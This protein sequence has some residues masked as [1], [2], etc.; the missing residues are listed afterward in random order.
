MIRINIYNTPDAPSEK[1]SATASSP[2]KLNFYYCEGEAIEPLEVKSYDEGAFL[3]GGS[4]NVFYWYRSE[5]DALEQDSTKRL[6]T[7]DPRGLIIQPSEM[8]NDNVSFADGN[9]VIT[10]PTDMSGTPVPGTYTFY[11]TQASNKKI[12]PSNDVNGNPYVGD[13]YYGEESEPLELTIYVRNVPIAPAV[14]DQTLFICETDVTPTFR[15]SGFDPKITYVWYDSLAVS[16]ASEQARGQ[17]FTPANYQNS[18]AQ[19]PG[20]YGYDVTQITDINLNNEGF[21]GCESPV[22]ELML[23]VRSIPDAPITTGTNDIY[24]IC[25]RQDVLTLVID[26]PDLRNTARYTWYDQDNAELGRGLTFDPS[27]Y[28]PTTNL[29][30]EVANDELFRVKY[31]HHI[32]TAENFAG[33]TSDFTDVIHRTNGLAELSFVDIESDNEYCLELT[34]IDFG[35]ETLGIGGSGRFSLFADFNTTGS[36]LTD[37]GDGTAV[38]NLETLHLQDVDLLDPQASADRLVV[39]GNATYRNIYYEFTDVN[40]C[41]NTDS[42]LN[43]V[44]NPYPAIDFRIDDEVTENYVTCLNDE[45]NI[46]GERTFFLE[47]F[48]TETGASIAKQ[49]QLSDFRIY[50]ELNNE[51]EVGIL[52]DLS[53]RAEFSPQDARKSLSTTDKDIQDYSAQNYY[54]LTLTHRDANGCTNTV[55]NRI[56]INP[57]P[58]FKTQTIGANEYIINNKACATETV[59]FDVD[60]ENI[61]DDQTTFTWFVENDQITDSQDLYFPADDDAVSVFANDY[62]IGGGETTIVLIAK[63]DNTGCLNR[64]SETKQIGVVPDVRFNFKNLTI[65]KETAF[66]FEERELDIRYSQVATAEMTVWDESDN[67]VFQR[68]IFMEDDQDLVVNTANKIDPG[69]DTLTFSN[70]GIYK[71]K[72]YFNSSA[73]CNSSDSV[74]FNILDKIV[75]GPEGILHTFNDGPEGWHTD[76]TSVDGFYQGLND[77]ILGR[78]LSTDQ[79]AASIPRYSTWEWATPDGRTLNNNNVGE[80]NVSGGAWITN[81]D[82]AYA[83]RKRNEN[84]VAENSWVYSPTY[85]LSQ[86]EKPAISFNY[87]SDMVNRDGVVLQ[88]SI[89]EGYTWTPIGEYD[90]EDGNSGINWYNASALP[91]NPG[92]IDESSFSLYNIE[93]FGW[94]RATNVPPGSPLGTASLS[95]DYNWYYAANKI[96][97]KDENGVYLIPNE[98]WSDIRFRFALG[99]NPGEKL[100]ENNNPIEGFAFDNFRIYD[101]QKVI[102]FE[103]FSSAL[104]EDSKTAE[105]IINDRVQKAGAGVVWVNYF[106]DLDGQNN[107]PTD[108]LFIRNEIDPGARGGYYGISESPTSVLDGEVIER[109]PIADNQSGR[110]LGWNQFALNKKELVDPQFDIA[111][112]ELAS[113]TTDELKIRGTFTSLINIP[114]N[115][116]LSF[117]FIVFENYVTGKD[118]GN[119]VFSDT[120]RNVMRAILPDAGGFVEKGSASIGDTY[121]FDIDW[122]IDA[123][124]NLDEL[125]VVAF[126]QNEVTREI[127]QVASINIDN[128]T[129]TLTGLENQIVR[130]V[131]FTIYPNP[132]NQSFKV[133]FDDAIPMDTKWTL[134]DQMGRIM[135]EGI[136]DKNRYELIIET[137]EISS[138]LYFLQLY[139]EMY[140]WEPK[141]VMIIH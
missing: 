121:E 77:S 30:P 54:T 10:T 100:D 63:D 8:K 97:A 21:E 29:N 49:G 110:L 32:N 107:R 70:P 86:L 4:E 84:P 85:D 42:V 115:S 135:K 1:S 88:Y 99:S 108:S 93:Q 136:M 91:G 24:T 73:N 9:G 6:A 58:Q 96:D 123:I 55:D 106:T 125:R 22:T 101:R 68:D 113:N 18:G 43:I 11:V 94:T 60:M 67:V 25:E 62:N 79:I 122:T 26:N 65:G 98:R 71:A 92:N 138:G 128:K 114:P 7:A 23:T 13:P 41:V 19:V 31:T 134:F 129:N 40:G 34:D 5:A 118:F 39:G 119:Y 109:N 111:L 2:G 75:V 140:R 61:Q 38:L 15:I 81:A 36:G 69:F 141:R 56:T 3:S 33:C 83:N 44:V 104:L 80:T 126:V 16:S 105:D 64:A 82:G 90:F 28:V 59:E 130:G 127:Y 35:A 76:S 48:Y 117:R 53:A 87:A 102:L 133:S 45:S 132:A 47:G 52:S 12:S 116:E 50:D 78:P 139:D 17:T 20:F 27:F 37:N 112:V 51:L 72:F 46:L 89:D 120:I 66:R 137:G 124:F 103:S 14:I 95:N 131:D 57:R 74:A